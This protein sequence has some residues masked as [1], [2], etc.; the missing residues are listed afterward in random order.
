MKESSGKQS[1]IHGDGDD[2]NNIIH[3]AGISL[4]WFAASA[5]LEVGHAAEQVLAALLA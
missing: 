5:S 3:L 1:S 4:E 2:L